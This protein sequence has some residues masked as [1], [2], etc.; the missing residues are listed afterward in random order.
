[1][2]L[3]LKNTGN[4][5][6]FITWLKGFK[7]INPTLLM[8]IDL[9][10]QK[11]VAKGFPD[12]RSIVKYSEISFENA[13]YEIEQLLDNDG[14]SL[15]TAKGALTAKYKT[16]FTKDNRIKAGIFGILVKVIDVM[17]M[18]AEVEHTMSFSFD[19]SE[20]V[21]Y[22][23]AP[24]TMQQWQSEKWTLTS[25]TL[26][27]TINC[28]QLSEFFRFLTD[29]LMLNTLCAMV[30]PMDFNVTP[31]TISNLTRISQL[32][33]SDKTR[34][35]IKFYPKKDGETYALY[36]FDETDKSYDYLLGYTTSNTVTED[37]S[38][39]I[40][41]ENFIN[42]TKALSDNMTISFSNSDSSRVIVT[43]GT[44]KIVIASYQK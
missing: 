6:K 41:R 2:Q 36:A 30:E 5:T 21:K 17:N 40:L 37:A 22:V 28:S 9:T 27:M 35:A 31:E 18:Y 3:V 42:A 39:A 19:T 44:S 25:K 8:E 1:M 11:F 43:S 38:I 15:L 4:I 7:D 32:F 13:G 14:N 26:S 20:N 29:D 10:D 12:S 23:Q 24:N 34:N 16:E 33:A